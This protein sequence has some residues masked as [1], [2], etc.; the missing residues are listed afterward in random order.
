MVRAAAAC[1][2]LAHF[3][4]SNAAQAAKAAEAEASSG[5]TV[6]DAAIEAYQELKIK[7]KYR[8]IIFKIS[9][10]NK[11]IVIDKAVEKA[12]YEQ[13]VT[14]LPA[15]GCRYAVYDFEFESAGGDGQRHKLLF[16]ICKDALRKKL[17]GVYTEIQC[18]DLSEV[19]HEAV[20]DK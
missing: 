5:V 6:N 3:C 12:E 7:R 13:F 1:S 4:P 19:S 10:D 9:D 2:A 11:Q 15:D 20:L 8:Y 18:T 14:S 17:D 16:Y